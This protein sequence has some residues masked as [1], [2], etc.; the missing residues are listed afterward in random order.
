MTTIRNKARQDWTVG[1][2]VKV[3]FVSDLEV[4]KRIPTPGDGFPDIFVL[5]QAA[6]NR[7]YSF[8]PHGGLCR[9]ASLDQ[10]LCAA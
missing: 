7:F 2:V 8:Q 5:W 10:A 6:T 4:V 9:H 1:E 3:G